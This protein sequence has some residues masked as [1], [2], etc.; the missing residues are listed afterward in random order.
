[1]HPH[2]ALPIYN[3]RKKLSGDSAKKYAW[4]LINE[5]YDI[6]D[7]E[8]VE[9]TIWYIL[10]NALTTDDPDISSLERANMIFFYEC[11]LSLHKAVFVLYENRVSKE[12]S[13]T[14][15]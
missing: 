6:Y 12:K 3:L 14:K 4:E 10:Y 5:F 15:K 7:V 2:Q 13:K 11:F 8:S 1:M 9:D